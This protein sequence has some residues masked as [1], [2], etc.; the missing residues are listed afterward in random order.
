[1][2]PD[3]ESDI[4]L[5]ASTAPAERA[6]PPEAMPPVEPPGQSAGPGD[7]GLETSFWSRD[8]ATTSASSRTKPGSWRDTTW[9]RRAGDTSFWTHAE[10][11]EATGEPAGAGRRVG[12]YLLVEPLGSGGQ[13]VV[14]RAV[15]DG[16]PPREVALKLLVPPPR[17]RRRRVDPPH[18]EARLGALLDHPSILEITDSG[19]VDGVPYLAMPLIEGGTLADA[20]DQ[21]RRRAARPHARSDDLW[22]AASPAPEYS[23]AVAG[24]VAQVARALHSAHESDV[25]HCDVKPSNIL[26]DRH[27]PERVYLADFGLALDLHAATPE[28]MR[29]LKGTPM[30]MA[31][32]KLRGRPG[33]GKLCDVYALGVTLFE[34]VTGVKPFLISDEPC[35]PAVLMAQVLAREP[36]RPRA[37][38]P[39]LSP[40]MEAIILTAMA[41]DPSR[42]YPH[43]AALA[44]DLERYLAGRE[45]V[46]LARR[47]G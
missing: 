15:E 5:G 35:S 21:R 22:L 34:A 4:R 47:A 11:A 44:E 6:R 38:S 39:R 42:R 12:P 31:P 13:A 30:Y 26:L 14:W 7:A 33:D 41:P 43:A 28:Q 36:L 16:P 24:V 20:L 46:A 17:S 45:V 29:A 18:G 27:R 23:R 37:V 9:M 19:I 32:E 3:D 25:I 10:A 8:R 1:M 2:L 40:R